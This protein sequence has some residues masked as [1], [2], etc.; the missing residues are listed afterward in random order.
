MEYSFK[1]ALGRNIN[2]NEFSLNSLFQMI[3]IGMIPIG[4][5]YEL[6]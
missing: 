4:I 6:K 5:N 2:D 3:H 1:G